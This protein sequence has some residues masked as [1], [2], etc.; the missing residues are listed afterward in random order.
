MQDQNHARPNHVTISGEYSA[1][2]V[3]QSYPTLCDPMDYRVHGIRQ[4][5]IL[6]G[7]AFPFSGGSSQLRDQTQVSCTAGGF[8]TSWATKEDWVYV[9]LHSPVPV[10]L[11][12]PFLF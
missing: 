12:F 1:V 8:F 5:R 11:N 9:N 4:A 2:Q 10:G 3:I 7:V 6:E